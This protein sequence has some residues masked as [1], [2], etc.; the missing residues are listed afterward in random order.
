MSTIPKVP[1]QQALSL[2]QA[3]FDQAVQLSNGARDDSKFM[4]WHEQTSRV[5]KG[6]FGQDEV[7]K[8]D[9]IYFSPASTSHNTTD[10]HYQEA[11]KRGLTAAT[12][13]LQGQMME[14]KNFWPDETASQSTS[15]CRQIHAAYS[16]RVRHAGSAACT[17]QNSFQQRPA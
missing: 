2:L 16:G 14:I 11:Y 5:M 17:A 7:D 12:A 4:S 8:L 15:P 9:E 3:Q 1:A 6:I 10:A 13:M